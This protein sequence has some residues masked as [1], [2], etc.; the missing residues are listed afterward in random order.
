MLINPSSM[1]KKSLEPNTPYEAQVIDENDPRKLGRIR[2]RV[3]GFMDYIPDDSLPWAR[4]NDWHHPEGLKP[5]GNSVQRSGAFGGVPKRGSKVHLYF[6]QGNEYSCTWSSSVAYDDKSKLPEFMRNYPNRLGI[7]LSDGTTIIFDTKT[8]EMYVI[9]AG[10]FHQVVMGDVNQHII[11][12]QQLIVS[13]DKGDIPSY[14]LNDP[15]M[16]IGSLSSHPQGRIP[17]KGLIGKKP[18]SQHS[19]ISGNQTIHVKGSRKEIIDGD[20]TLKV[21]RD[22]KIEAGGRI[23]SNGVRIDLG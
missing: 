3:N 13:G 19:E 23:M 2:A 22:Y 10:D 8:K 6:P 5:D 17:F 9:C 21:K 7:K 1:A 11:G 12:N 14:L 4:P 18:G 15:H 16:V 20:Y